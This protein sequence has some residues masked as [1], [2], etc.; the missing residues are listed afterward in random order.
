MAILVTGGA[1]YIGSHMTRLLEESGEKPVVIDNL[2]TGHRQAVGNSVLVEGDIND[3]ALVEDVLRRYGITEVVHFAACS[4]VAES[5]RDPALYYNNNVGGA[6]SLLDA[7]RRVGVDKIVFSS[8]AS[9]YGIPAAGVE[10][11]T[12]DL[13]CN[14]INHYGRSKWMVEQILRAY[15]EA[16]GLRS[17]ALRYFNA[18]GAHATGEIGEAHAVET[19]LIP[20]ILKNLQTGKTTT[21]FGNDYNTL[22]GTNVRD[23]IHIDDLIDAHVRALEALRRGCKTTAYN[24]GSGNGYSNNEVLEAVERVTGRTPQVTYGDR[25]GGDPDSLIA[26]HARASAELGWTP[27]KTLDDMIATAWAWHEAHPEGY[28]N[29]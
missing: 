3:G 22:D 10:K 9:L 28:N 8:T 7:M 14:P 26:S 19:H 13:P 25:R 29:T 23:Y 18:A 4:L 1:G 6:M 12:E 27:R 17:I 24:L 5:N 20:N 11:I 21:I 2:R 16:Y 15:S